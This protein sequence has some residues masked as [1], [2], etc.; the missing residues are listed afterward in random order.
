MPNVAPFPVDPVLTGIAISYS[1]G[2][3][4]ADRVMPRKPVGRQLFQ[5]NSF[6]RKERFTIP[7]TVVGRTGK[8]NQVE[9]GATR[10]ESST[11]DYALDDP[12]PAADEENIS[13][14]A[15]IDPRADA[16][17]GITDLIQLDRE[18]RVA[19]Q[20]ASH[21]NYAA[22]QISAPTQYNKWDWYGDSTNAASDP[23]D[24]VLGA[25]DAMIIK[26]NTMLLGNT[27]ATALR[28]HPRIVQA[29]HANEGGEGVVPLQYLAQL[30]DVGEILVGEAWYNTANPGQDEVL[31][32]VWGALCS[33]FY[34][35]PNANFNRGV[36][37][38][39]T[40]QWGTR[41]SGA[42]EDKDLGMRGGVRVRVGESVKELVLAA[43]CA[44][45]FEDVLSQA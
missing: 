37:W 30:F 35:N 8:P 3:Y 44:W 43:D 4:V 14:I 18:V 42:I 12:I 5:W 10:S 1:N 34:K 2:N 24:Q 21:A 7:D 22:S 36:T 39:L 23:L 26:P 38:A 40:A 31:S 17:E 16:V 45:L 28:K 6:I 32:R 29:W 41:I 19:G 15:G 20:V 9:F 27:V 13:S 11:Q 25:M 33:L